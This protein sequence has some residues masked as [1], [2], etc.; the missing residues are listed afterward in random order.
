MTTKRRFEGQT[1]R[2]GNPAAAADWDELY[3]LLWTDSVVE[4]EIKE[5]V[6]LRNA[7]VHHCGL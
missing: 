4:Q 6:R 1:W 3:F 7:R 5:T 2:E